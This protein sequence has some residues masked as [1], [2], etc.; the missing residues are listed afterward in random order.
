MPPFKN[1]IMAPD[2]DNEEHT[3]HTDQTNAS[4][5]ATDSEKQHVDTGHN[6]HGFMA[7]ATS[8]PAGYYRS[9]YLIGS[10]FAIGMGLLAGVA[11]FGYAAPILGVINADIGPSPYLTW[12]AIVYTLCVAV[13]LTLVGRLSDLFGR[14]YFFIGGAILGTIGS[15]VCATAQSINSLIGGTT[16]IGLGAATQLS[17][18]FVTAELVPMR[19]R[20]W[21][22]SIVYAFSIPGSGFGPAVAEAFVV[23]YPSVGWRGVYYLLIGIN[24]AALAAWTLFYWPPTFERKHK[25]AR[26]ADFVK[27]FD[28]IGTFLYTSG[29]LLFLM[30]LSMGGDSVFPWKS[31]PTLALLIIGALCLI[32]LGAWVWFAKPKEP[33][34][35][36]HIIRN[37]AFVASAV[38]LGLGASIYYAF[39]IVWPQMV[40]VLYNNGDSIY[41]GYLSCIVG[42]C[43]ILGQISGGL[44]A[45][46]I[47][48]V[49]YQIMATFSVGGILLACR[50]SP[51]F[52][53]PGRS[54]A[55][56]TYLHF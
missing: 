8:M 25:N 56:L 19:A 18:H 27:N 48:R 5:P 51:S 36:K 41:G 49:K 50:C 30:G 47:G 45:T 37:G 39:A 20:F 28:Y 1:I 22:V 14:R 13:G 26:I 40:G 3:I 43:F 46:A 7:D 33:L 17:F 16:L 11:G 12:V 2:E 54:P 42:A 31:A 29:L 44:M 34:I 9:P 52:H 35:P 24:V 21:T 4:Q 53:G 32:A 55:N 23:R 15:I 10:F 6:L 38:L